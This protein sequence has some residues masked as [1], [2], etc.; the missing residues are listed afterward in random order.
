[1][2]A[3]TAIPISHDAPKVGGEKPTLK[4]FFGNG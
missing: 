2:A 4:L 3:A 1:L